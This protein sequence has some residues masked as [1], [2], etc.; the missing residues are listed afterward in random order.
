VQH[1]SRASN[2]RGLSCHAIQEVAVDCP[3]A[4]SP[5]KYV[6]IHAQFRF[7]FVRWV[8]CTIVFLQV[9]LLLYPLGDV[10]W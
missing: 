10:V 6:I 4:H 8:R 9:K 3:S 5:R 7:S 1:W 2:Q